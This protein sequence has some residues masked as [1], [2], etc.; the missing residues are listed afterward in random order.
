MKN[1][2][3]KEKQQGVVLVVSLIMLLLLTIIGVSV[4]RMVTSSGLA[5]T[6]VTDRSKAFTDAEVTIRDGEDLIF[7]A[8]SST[9][10]PSGLTAASGRLV[11]CTDTSDSAYPCTNVP[12]D[13]SSAW[14]S[15]I[16][17]NESTLRTGLSPSYHIEFLG[18]VSEVEESGALDLSRDASQQGYATE[19]DSGTA[20]YVYYRV[21]ARSHD[22]TIGAGAE[23]AVVKIQTMVRRTFP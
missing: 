7:S 22:P 21:T 14:V 10:I 17:G 3:Y 16:S 4:S 18:M 9:A 15:G 19:V 1:I 13:S 5:T 8:A 2:A 23:R 20:D 6:K 11:D 12:L